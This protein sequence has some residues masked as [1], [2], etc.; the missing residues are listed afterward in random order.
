MAFKIPLPVAARGVN[1]LLFR[2]PQSAAKQLNLPDFQ[3]KEFTDITMIGQ[4]SFGKVF[5][6]RKDGHDFV[7]KQL[8]AEN[9]SPEDQRLFVKEAE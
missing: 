5:K 4:G 1:T 2:V 6:G 7:I 8:A 9:A 3:K